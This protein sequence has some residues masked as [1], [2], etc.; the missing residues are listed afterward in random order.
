VNRFHTHTQFS[1]LSSNFLVVPPLLSCVQKSN[2]F[3]SCVCERL[4][5]LFF[6]W[7]FHSWI[8]FSH[9]EADADSLFVSFHFIYFSLCSGFISK[10][11]VESIRFLM[12]QPD[13][14]TLHLCA[15]DLSFFIAWS[16]FPTLIQWLFHI[17]SGANKFLCV[18]RFSWHNPQFCLINQS[19]K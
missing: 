3:I 8:F 6:E 15:S 12:F 9:L 2:F 5:T 10:L 1:T 11:F 17:F 4:L 16:V 7:K 13:F 19:L 14:W 18:P